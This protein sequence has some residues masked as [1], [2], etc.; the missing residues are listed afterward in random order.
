VIFKSPNSL[1]PL[2]HPGSWETN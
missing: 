1:L 2:L